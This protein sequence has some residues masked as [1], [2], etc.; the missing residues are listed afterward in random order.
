MNAKKLCAS[1]AILGLVLLGTGAVAEFGTI[2][3]VPAATLLLP[4]FEVDLDN[5]DGINTLFSVNNASAAPTIAHVVIWSDM[6]IPV[7]DFNIYLTGYDV[8]TVSLYD[9]FVNGNLPQT[10]DLDSDPVDL[11]SPNGNLGDIPFP[12]QDN[13]T[14]VDWD[15][16]MG[17][18]DAVGNFL[19]NQCRGPLPPVPAILLDRLQEGLTGNPTTFDGGLCVGYDHGD[20]IARGYITVDNA[21]D[22]SVDFPGD[23]G[24]FTTGP[25]IRVNQLWGDFFIV[26]SANDFAFGETLVHIEA[27][28]TPVGGQSFYGRYVTPQYSGVDGR[29]ALG[30][31]YGVRYL[32]GGAFDGGTDLIVWREGA[33]FNQA[34]DSSAFPCGTG[35]SWYPMN[36]TS[37]VAFDEQEQWVELCTPL[38]DITPIS[39]PLDN[40][41]DPTCFPLEAQRTSV[42]V[43]DLDPGYLFGWLFLD[44][45]APEGGL[46][47]ENQAWVIANMSALGRFSVGFDAIQLNNVTGDI[48]GL[49]N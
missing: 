30:N 42:G 19:P 26:D 12:L 9:I 43:G 27:Q 6:T 21:D 24:Y 25:E 39:P 41:T 17:T 49:T 20:R 34:T 10:A 13:V 38:V 8:Q 22:C 45:Q 48:N 36:E 37:V 4:Y 40:S 5:V 31:Q 28:D 11:I 47:V 1:F 33:P 23:A 29:E 35:P 16:I 46:S 2:D 14:E 44:L 3:A 32:N 18:P 15:Q 7:L